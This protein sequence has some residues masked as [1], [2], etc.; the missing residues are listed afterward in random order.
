[1]RTR[2]AGKKIVNEA[3]LVVVMGTAY[4]RIDSVKVK[5]VRKM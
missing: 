5:I 4:T 3:L 1:V 2:E